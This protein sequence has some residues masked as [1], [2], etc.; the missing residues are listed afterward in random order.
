M[1]SFFLIL[2]AGFVVYYL[3]RRAMFGKWRW[4]GV[5]VVLSV[6]G[7]GARSAFASNEWG[8]SAERPVT[9]TFSVYFNPDNIWSQ[10]SGVGLVWDD[11]GEYDFLAWF[12]DWV[13]EDPESCWLLDS[14][15]FNVAT[16]GLLQQDEDGYQCFLIRMVQRTY[17][18]GSQ[19]W[20]AVTAARYIVATLSWQWD[21]TMKLH[22]DGGTEFGEYDL[23]DDPAEST[24]FGQ[25]RFDLLSPLHEDLGTPEYMTQYWTGT[26]WSQLFIVVEVSDVAVQT[27]VGGRASTQPATTGPSVSVAGVTTAVSGGVSSIAT[28]DA[29]A[30][31]GTPGMK[32]ASKRFRNGTFGKA[33]SSSA[34]A[35]NKL[36]S[37]MDSLGIDTVTEP[38]EVG[39]IDF[40]RSLFDSHS[41]ITMLGQ[42]QYKY[43]VYV[44]EGGL[45]E[46]YCWII[47]PITSVFILYW[48]LTRLIVR[49]WAAVVGSAAAEKLHFPFA[50]EHV[51][52]P[53]GSVLFDYGD[54]GTFFER[55]PELDQ[56]M[57]FGAQDEE[58]EPPAHGE[59]VTDEYEGRNYAVAD[60]EIVEGAEVTG[61][62]QLG[63]RAFT[64]EDT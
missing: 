17:D 24:V 23:Y 1:M 46:P 56:T 30:D 42:F 47:R 13:E 5:L 43:G 35:E 19:Q 25:H 39:G 16:T 50:P 33:S 10:S 27:M 18:A 52:F 3:G 37:A 61:R 8:P 31:S 53:D 44:G 4:F 29:A 55:S 22:L 36:R 38:G 40:M 63:S 11:P 58:R 12:F 21:G 41:W 34:A 49:G 48:L 2:A 32:G 45:L 60:E 26:Q 28:G 14:W 15:R 20:G 57:G 7:V 59:D 62:R 64:M 54:Q 9:G 51:E 6:V